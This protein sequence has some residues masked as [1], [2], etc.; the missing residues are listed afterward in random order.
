MK[1]IAEIISPILRESGLEEGVRLNLI[2]S[3]WDGLFREP[4]S[5]HLY[6]VSLKDGELLMNVDSPVW[7][8]EVTLHKEEIL[9]VLKPFNVKEIRFRHGRSGFRRQGNRERQEDKR[10]NKGLS[11]ESLN[12][13]D[14]TIGPL[15]DSELK[16]AIRS[17]MEKSLSDNRVN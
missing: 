11:P 4:L 8:Q 3:R 10:L 5:H 6:P 9:K 7:L 15:E 16:D 13:I 1:S 2:K 17:A 14:E 12:F